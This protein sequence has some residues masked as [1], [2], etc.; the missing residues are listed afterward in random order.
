MSASCAASLLGHQLAAGVPLGL[1]S[2]VVSQMATM[3]ATC[4]LREGPLWLGVEPPLS[5][6]QCRGCCFRLYLCAPWFCR[7]RPWIRYSLRCE[8]NRGSGGG[9]SSLPAARLMRS[10]PSQSSMAC[11]VL[12]VYARALGQPTLRVYRTQVGLGLPSVVPCLS[13]TPAT[14]TCG[15]GGPCDRA[16]WCVSA[17]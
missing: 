9:G 8:V 11:L 6:H 2:A 14:T 1:A 13:T 4:S 7:W 3:V 17:L 5:R 10:D 12:V 16:L 15:E